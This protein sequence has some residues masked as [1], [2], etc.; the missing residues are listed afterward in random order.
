MAEGDQII[1]Q[2]IKN[3]FQ[4]DGEDELE[5]C[6]KLCDFS[7][8]FVL[9]ATAKMLNVIFLP[10]TRPFSSEKPPVSMSAR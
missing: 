7:T 6:Q 5:N 1:I 3:L 2:T 10:E 9:E 8:D 4:E